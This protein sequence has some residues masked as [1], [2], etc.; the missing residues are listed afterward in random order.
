MKKKKIP[1]YGNVKRKNYRAIYEEK[2]YDILGQLKLPLMIVIFSTTVGVLLFMI[3][4][5]KSSGEDVVNYLF[6][7][8]IT[9]STVGYT[10]AYTDNVILNRLLASLFIIVAFPLGY[11]YGLVKTVQVLV[12]GNL[13]YIYFY[14]RMYKKME[15]LKDHFIITPYNEITKE[16]IKEF[17]RKQ[18]PFV[19]IEPDTSKESMIKESGV[20]YFVFDEPYKRAVLLGVFIDRAR[21]LITAHEEN[22]QDLAVIV[23]ARLIRPDKDSFYIFAT[24]TTEGSAEKMRL[25]GANEV[26]VPQ[27]TIGKR[28]VSM[29]L[30][31][32]SPFVS[33]FLDKIAFGE[34]TDID[35]AEV[36]VDESSWIVNKQLKDIHLRQ[37]TRTT[38]V[39]IV[40]PDGRMDIAPTG[41]TVIKAGYT[42]LLL[43]K[44]KDIEKAKEFIQNSGG[45]NQ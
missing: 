13:D 27:Q 8:V 29:V 39:A 45:V 3:T 43:G 19:L 23:T 5:G 22:T 28:I 41:D 44:P 33:N 14:W 42:L 25:L 40:K 18:I 6:H 38:V 30:H 31:P 11:M 12:A 36:Y 21:G 17:K 16:I 24:A 9:I 1:H 32:P 37:T 15:N 2:F 20:E 34:R 7:T 26:I 35:I 10:E 4:N